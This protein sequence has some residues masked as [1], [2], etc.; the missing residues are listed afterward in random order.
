MA[1]KQPRPAWNDD[2]VN[3]LKAI[4]AS[5]MRKTEKKVSKA[6][7]AAK[8]AKK[9]M[10]KQGKPEYASEITDFMARQ[11]RERSIR[12]AERLRG[13]YAL[14]KAE[15]LKKQQKRGGGAARVATMAE[16]AE[17]KGSV[18]RRGREVPVSKKKTEE[19]KTQAQRATSQSKAAN[20]KRKAEQAEMLSEYRRLRKAGDTKAA[21]VVRKRFDAHVKKYGRYS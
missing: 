6:N 2:A 12:Q 4:L 8:T 1:R 20:A 18:I 5:A 21:G 14:Q 19:L 9:Q 13:E 3:T 16:A 17:T 7:R 11:K 10:R 15:M